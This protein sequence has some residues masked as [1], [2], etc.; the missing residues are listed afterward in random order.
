MKKGK[1]T[2]QHVVLYAKG[3]YHH[4]DDI[5]RDLRFALTLDDYS[6]EFFS[7]KDIIRKLLYECEN[8][9]DDNRFKLGQIYMEIQPDRTLMHGYLH[10]QI[11]K[12][13]RNDRFNYDEP[14]DFNKAILMYIL[15]SLRFIKS[16]EQWDAIAPVYGQGLGK[17]YKIKKHR[18]DE[19]FNKIK[20][21]A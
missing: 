4:T 1:F 5:Y 18:V 21:H 9:S 11:P 15:S 17:P 14:Y 7:D 3:W 20:E 6:G 10:D 19:M 12:Y 8:L 13:I 16:G 2:L